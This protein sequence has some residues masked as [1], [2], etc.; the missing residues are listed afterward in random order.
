MLLSTKKA[1]WNCDR[2]GAESIDQI[3]GGSTSTLTIFEIP[4]YKHTTSL[5]LFMF[6]FIS[7]MFYSFIVYNIGFPFIC[8]IYS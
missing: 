1:N 5:H 7:T 3:L 4:M 6:L 8:Q 2:N